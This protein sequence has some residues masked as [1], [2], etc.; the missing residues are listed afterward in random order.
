MPRLTISLLRFPLKT[1]DLLDYP[2][3]GMKSLTLSPEKSVESV[4]FL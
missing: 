2:E 3:T 1:A 4:G